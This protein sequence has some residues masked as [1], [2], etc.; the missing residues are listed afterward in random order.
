MKLIVGLGNPG[1]RYAATRHNI[2]FR[3]VDVLAERHGA[4]LRRMRSGFLRLGDNLRGLAGIA[5]IHGA[6]CALLQPLTYMNRSGISVAKAVGYYGIALGDLLIICDDVHLPPGA[7]RL[8][9]KGS[10]GGHRGLESIAASLRTEDFARLRVGVGQPPP[11]QD[12]ADYVLS[13]FTPDEQPL[14]GQAVAGAADGVETW[15]AEEIEVA[16]DRFNRPTAQPT[17]SE[18]R[19]PQQADTTRTDTPSASEET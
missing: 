11:W 4:T 13:P 16:M 17:E 6:E 18:C 2:G 9:K 5:A 1:G 10:A 8:R 14:M 12:W 3:V 15:L 19:P 7:L